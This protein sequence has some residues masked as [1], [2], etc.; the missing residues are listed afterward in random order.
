MYRF[1]LFDLGGVLFD[2]DHRIASRAVARRCRVGEERVHEIL[3]GE[4]LEER[5]DVGE[6]ST[7]EFHRE[8][9][10]RGG[11]SGEVA[12]LR[13][14]W[15]AIF[16]IRPDSWRLVGEL[17]EAGI[18]LGIVSN[19]NEIHLERLSSMVDFRRS[20]RWLFPSFRL[21]CRK[22]EAAYYQAVVSNLPMPPG[23]GLFV[24]DRP[25]N[26]PP[27]E[28]AGFATHLFRGVPGLEER[29]RGI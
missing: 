22:P 3:F 12:D 8:L 29:L 28:E 9:V 18:P 20:F 19:T 15:G 27:A 11:Y 25:E 17:V 5:Y 2:F 24:D 7:R 13:Q 10:E 26:L 6:I 4:G 14:D 1:V 23:A 16:E 21:H